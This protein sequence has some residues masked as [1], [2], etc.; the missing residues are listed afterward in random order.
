MLGTALL[1]YSTVRL[2][3]VCFDIVIAVLMASNPALGPEVHTSMRFKFAILPLA[4]SIEIGVSLTI[5]C[6]VSPSSNSAGALEC[7]LEPFVSRLYLP[8]FNSEIIS[9]AGLPW[10]TKIF[11]GRDISSLAICSSSRDLLLE[12]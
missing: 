7:A 9:V 8:E 10:R 6:V 4:T 12:D 5:L 1:T 3:F 11:D 2:A